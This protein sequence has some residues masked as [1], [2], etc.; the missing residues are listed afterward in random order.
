M[1]KTIISDKCLIC[2]QVIEPGQ[3][4]YLTKANLVKTQ[5]GYCN[6]PLP[7]GSLRIE[8]L[9]SAKP[10]GGIHLECWEGLMEC[11]KFML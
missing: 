6:G 10:R 1:A 2:G 4:L 8:H 3:E 7:D 9:G 5:Y 11:Q